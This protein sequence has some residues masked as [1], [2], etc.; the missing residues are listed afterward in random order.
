ML[1]QSNIGIFSGMEAKL[2]LGYWLVFGC[3][4]QVF[5]ISS[6]TYIPINPS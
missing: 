1:K 6:S 3:F 5:I 2:D 4:F